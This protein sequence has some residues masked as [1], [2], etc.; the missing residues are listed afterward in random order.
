RPCFILRLSTHPFNPCLS[1]SEPRTSWG[2]CPT[3]CQSQGDDGTLSHPPMLQPRHRRAS[4]LSRCCRLSKH[5]TKTQTEGISTS[6]L[7]PL[8]RHRLWPGTPPAPRDGPTH[9]RG[10]PARPPGRG[11]GTAS[12]RTWTAAGGGCGALRS[13]RR[14][15]ARSAATTGPGRHRLPSRPHRCPAPP[16]ARIQAI[17]QEPLQQP[18]E[19]ARAAVSPRGR[20]CPAR[21]R[22][23]PEPHALGLAHGAVA[24]ADDLHRLLSAG[25]GLIPRPIRAFLPGRVPALLLRRRRHGSACASRLPRDAARPRPIPPRPRPG[26]PRGHGGH[27]GPAGRSAAAAADPGAAQAGRR[28]PSARARGEAGLDRTGPGTAQHGSAL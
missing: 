6:Q 26:A 1:S 2:Q 24:Q 10:P 13:P 22:G 15:R 18:A 12:G 11:A 9:P 4:D 7:F 20:R 3:L 14:R 19:R 27:G 17:E 8:P 25:R 16:L 5:Q 28:G 23:T 21:T